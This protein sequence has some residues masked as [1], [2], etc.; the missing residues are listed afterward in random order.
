MNTLDIIFCILFLWSIYRGFTKGFIIQ[1]AKLAALLLG[2]LGAIYFSDFTADFITE[3]FHYSNQYLP[4][5]AFAITF[6]IIV[7][8]IQ[9]TAR[10]FNKLIEEGTLGTIN[11]I[12]GVLFSIVKMAFIISIVLVLFNKMNNKYN[13]MSEETKQESYLYKPLSGFAPVIFPYL[14]FEKIREKIDLKQKKEEQVNNQ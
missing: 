13:F 7:I 12:L 9:L 14:K 8:V 3:K 6:V 4:V 5:I 2:I 10:Y 1:L 11:R